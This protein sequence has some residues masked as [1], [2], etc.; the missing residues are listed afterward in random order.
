ML[1]FVVFSTLFPAPGSLLHILDTQLNE[2]EG[3]GGKRADLRA[4]MQMI[5]PEPATRQTNAWSTVKTTNMQLA[6]HRR[7]HHKGGKENKQADKQKMMVA[8]CPQR[9]PQL[10]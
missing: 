3:E 10:I 1:S 7:E 5:R 9:R 2:E 4:Q 8:H 6:V